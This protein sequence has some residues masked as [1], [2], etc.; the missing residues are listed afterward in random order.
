MCAV[1]AWLTVIVIAACDATDSHIGGLESGDYPRQLAAAVWFAENPS[2]QAVPALAG[3][4]RSEDADVRLA[5]AKAILAGDAA[6]A[7]R[8]AL[9]TLARDVSA[10]DT[11]IA[12]AAMG[13]LTVAGGVALPT[14]ISIAISDS[15]PVRRMIATGAVL[16]VLKS[17]TQGEREKACDT[18]L[19]GVSDTDRDRYIAAYALLTK[20]IKPLAPEFIDRGLF[21]RST[22]VRRS[23]VIA[24]GEARVV[25]FAEPISLLLDTRSTALLLES[26]RA[27]G[28]IGDPLV[29]DRLKSLLARES[30]LE[31]RE[32][33]REA[34]EKLAVR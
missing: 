23:V 21:H 29:T 1:L 33:V 24:A 26:V 15:H 9:Q 14:L 5:C 8:E 34:L 18:A 10:T 13:A 27:L 31:V 20:L 4:L 17:V 19:D 25:L 2:R 6:S 11:E 12:K 28:E 32:A 16:L 22:L 7:Q 30:G 3:Q